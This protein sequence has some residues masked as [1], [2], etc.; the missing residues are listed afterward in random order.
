MTDTRRTVRSAAKLAVA[1]LLGTALLVGAPLVSSAK[2]T[3]QDLGSDY[4]TR[5]DPQRAMRQIVKQANAL[6]LTVRFDPIQA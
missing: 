5:R 1:I 2:V 6:G 3:H 4:F